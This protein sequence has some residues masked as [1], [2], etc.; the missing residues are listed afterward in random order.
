MSDHLTRLHQVKH[1]LIPRFASEFVL[2]KIESQSPT[3]SPANSSIW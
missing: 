2:A 3:G 1:Y